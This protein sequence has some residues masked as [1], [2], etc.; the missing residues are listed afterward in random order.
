MTEDMT[1]VKV[2]GDGY[3]MNAKFGEIDNGQALITETKFDQYY[4]YSMDQMDS[5]GNSAPN[6]GPSALQGEDECKQM[7]GGG[8]SCCTHVV[9][10]DRGSGKQQSF[11]RCMNQKVVDMSFHVEIDGMSM[12]M[13]C[14]GGASSAK[15]LAGTAVASMATLAAMTL[16]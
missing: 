3:E 4:M 8:D 13:G 10:T 16:I 2:E 7:A 6:C 15:Y 1:G 14:A 5:D 11:Y 12:A 9:M